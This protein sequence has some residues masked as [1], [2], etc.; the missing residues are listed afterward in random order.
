[1]KQVI[2]ETVLFTAVGYF[3]ALFVCRIVGRKMISQMTFFDYVIGVSIGSVIANIAISSGV[4][5]ASAITALITLGILTLVLDFLHIKSFIVR[6]IVDSEPVV[7]IENGKLVNQNMSRERFT[8]NELLMQLREKNIFNIAD[9]EFAVL[10]TD[11]NL[12]VLPKSQKAPVTP[13]DLNIPTQY[14]GLTRDLVLDGRLQPENLNDTGLDVDWLLNELKS[15]GI[16]DIKEAFYAGL[17]SS[18][19]LFVSKRKNTQEKQGQ[20]GIE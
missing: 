15:H 17:D 7:V 19:N 16:E 20:H 14:K 13:S 3:L 9:V 12:S 1:M 2:L 11:G 4:P 8:I 18:G 10:E 6:K 5:K